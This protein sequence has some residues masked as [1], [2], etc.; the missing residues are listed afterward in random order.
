MASVVA[1]VMV[2]P[3]TSPR[4][5]PLLVSLVAGF[6]VVFARAAVT[7]PILAFAF[8]LITA[9]AAAAVVDVGA[10]VASGGTKLV[11]VKVLLPRV[12]TAERGR[13]RIGAP[14]RRLPAAFEFFLEER[15]KKTGARHDTHGTHGTRCGEVWHLE[16]ALAVDDG[17]VYVPV[18]V[19]L[20]DEVHQPPAQHRI[21]HGTLQRRLHTRAAEVVNESFIFYTVVVV[22][23]TAVRGEEG[24]DEPG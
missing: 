14:I 13:A 9:V 12:A 23:A 11:D 20:A 18:E 21:P 17:V 6:R 7:P 22:A 4:A 24:G 2:M 1:V 19:L 3:I 5:P 10:L 8:A 15:E 16:H